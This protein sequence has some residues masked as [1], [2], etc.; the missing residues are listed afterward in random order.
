MRK[1]TS[2]LVI[3]FIAQYTFAQVRLPKIFGDHMVLQRSRDINVW[4]WAAPREKVTVKFHSQSKQATTDKD[5][6]WKIVLAPEEAGGPFE[7]TV[8]GKS[9]SV[10]FKDVLVGEVWV[11]SGQSNMEWP[12]RATDNAEAAIAAANNSNIRH[13]KIP[14]TVASQ[15]MSDIKAG[16]WKVASPVTVADF[17][18]VGYFFAQK[19]SKEL[20]VPVGLI[21]TSW[22]GT[23]SETWTS[24]E[25]FE[26]SDEFKVM[27]GKMPKL[28][29]E[30]ISKEKTQKVA[31]QV[32]SV[33]GSYPPSQNEV[34][35]WSSADLDDSKWPT[36]TLPGQWEGQSWPDLDG[37]V[38]FR[39]SFDLPAPDAAKEATLW[40][41]MVDDSDETYINGVKVGATTNEWNKLREYSVKAGV[42]KQGRNVI[43][44]KATDTGGGGGIHGEASMLHLLVGQH[45][46]P[47]D[48]KWGY[49]IES[50]GD[51]NAVGPNDYPTLLYN[52]ML[53]PLIPYSIRGALWYQG[54]ANAGRAY[55]YRTEFPL[56]IT[57]WRKHW[58]Q[59]D[60][61]F[62]FVQLASWNADNGN[63]NNGS[64]WAEL[65]EAQTSTLSLPNTGM[66]VTIDIGNPTDIH[67]RNKLDVGLRLAAVAL[68]NTYGKSVV[69]RGPTFKQRNGMYIE[70]DNVGSGLM[71]KDKYGYVRGFEVA[72]SD[73]KFYPA[74][75]FVEG[76]RI[77]LRSEQVKDVTIVH[78]GWEDDAGECNLFNKEGFPAEPFRVGDNDKFIT[79]NNKFILN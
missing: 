54:E 7:L 29:L 8:T 36:M 11:C 24:R 39:K 25:G 61:P 44:V 33:Q 57:D 47:L 46:V 79:K 70:F 23:H 69:D 20:N 15:P 17:T 48:G 52:A 58:A 26:S 34:S 64:T 30:A 62:Y 45:N 28:D 74:Q 68:K 12:L 18:A 67:P 76:N 73:G 63:S 1:L 9:T 72:G 42:L 2:L 22:G 4:G 49:H 3:I 43:V 41:S 65:R 21:N 66:A 50:A 16:E 5:G 6:K 51:A 10:I 75:A 31:Q 59:G 71:V 13:I 38:W 53:N 60:F 40:V 55:Q 27:I 78:Y 19:I 32:S 56:M 37:I 77:L 14:N 35:T